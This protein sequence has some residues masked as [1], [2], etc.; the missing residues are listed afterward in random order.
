MAPLQAVCWAFAVENRCGAAPRRP[1]GKI[2][3]ISL[4]SVLR[5]ICVTLLTSYQQ[6]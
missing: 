2:S 5:A 3:F 1:Y 4:K 6:A